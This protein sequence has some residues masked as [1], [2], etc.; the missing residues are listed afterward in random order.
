ME[1]I[2]KNTESRY[3]EGFFFF[4]W[5]GGGAARSY[6]TGLRYIPRW[7]FKKI[8]KPSRAMNGIPRSVST[9]YFIDKPRNV[10]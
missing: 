1:T 5:G 7:G 4:F 6:P 10:M 9:V 2:R 8:L 3:V